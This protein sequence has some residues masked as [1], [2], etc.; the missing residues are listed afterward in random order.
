MLKHS[1]QVALYNANKLSS[2]I[3]EALI[4][5]EGEIT[6]EIEEILKLKEWSE[7][8]LEAEADLLAMSLERIGQ[9]TN[10]YSDQIKHLEKLIKGLEHAQIRLGSEIQGAMEKLNLDSIGGQYKHFKLR[11]NPPKVEIL[12]EHAVTDEFKELKINEMIKKKAIGDALKAGE[13]LPWARLVQGKSL[14]IQT[15]KPKLKESEN[16]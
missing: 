15:S 10:Y 14:T 13:N 6:P 3:E 16:E 2:Q 11:Q 5:S 12:D 4:L 9:L 1:F 8:D 7:K